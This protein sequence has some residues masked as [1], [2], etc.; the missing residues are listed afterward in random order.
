[1]IRQINLIL[2]LAV[3]VFGQIFTK[4][5]YDI[6]TPPEMRE[7]VL[8]GNGIVDILAH[9]SL[10]WAG[11]GYGLNR[12]ITAGAA[13][14]T[15]G[16]ADYLG[17]GGV[18]AMALMS[19]SI[20]WIA[21][22]FDTV[23]SSGTLPAGGGLSYTTDQ[24]KSWIHIPQPVDRRDETGYKPTTTNVQNL[25]FDI[26]FLDTTVWITS[27]G[28]GLRRSNDMGASWQVVTTD[29]IPFSALDYLNHRAFSVMTENGN[30]WVGTAGGIS[31]SSDGGESWKR[32]TS[33]NQEFP[34]S[35][36][37]VVAL[38]YQEATGAV[39]AATNVTDST[40][41]T[42]VSKTING[43]AS[44]EICLEGVF[45]HNFAFD[46]ERVYVATDDGLY[47]S[48][49]GGA[50]WYVV[51]QIRDDLTGEEILTPVFYSAGVSRESGATRLWAGSSDG[52]ASTVNNGFTWTV[53]RSF[54]S[55]RLGSV[56]AVYAYP[57][58]FSPSRHG[59]IRFQ[60]DIGKAGDVTID[61]Y[62]FA[63]EHVVTIREYETA[64]IDNTYDR[65]AKWNGKTAEGRTVASGVY[66][67]RADV[68]G[69]ITWGKLIVIN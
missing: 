57:S 37:F 13:W 29:G 50:D 69:E 66:F 63:M 18:T 67:F 20:L 3:C 8:L 36:N 16:P 33:R 44:W 23:T 47:V 4:S 14:Q 7:G 61:I 65:S 2:L 31:K 30:I 43:G 60:Y 35:G 49:D 6:K 55:T 12:T 5:G 64:P 25:T 22:S 21:T 34:I 40:E 38:G 62:N 46:G 68:Q 53:Y 51:T 10:V 54:Q 52:L 26:A 59:Y 24:G 41:T 39:W 48:D 27:F 11:T 56:P 45:A 9:D 28:G 32:Y 19:D 1:M 17:K 42:G 58:P 15:Y